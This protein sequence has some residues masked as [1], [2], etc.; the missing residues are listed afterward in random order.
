MTKLLS[1]DFSISYAEPGTYISQVNE[2][3]YNHTTQ[4][5]ANGET[6]DLNNWVG[7]AYGYILAL[8]VLLTETKI[9]LL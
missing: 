5:E 9:D 1:F 3:G 4:T 6:I 7:L 8:S 2:Y